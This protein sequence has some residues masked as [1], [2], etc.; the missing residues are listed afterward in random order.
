[1][2]SHNGHV[3]QA[4]VTCDLGSTSCR[5]TPDGVRWRAPWGALGGLFEVLGHRLGSAL[6]GLLKIML[7]N[8][9]G[10]LGPRCGH[11]E[12]ILGHLAAMLEH[13]KI[14]L[15]VKTYN[16]LAIFIVHSFFSSFELEILQS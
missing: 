8:I 14:V 16:S 11:F 9:L 15:F 6:V 12:F 2:S 13:L 7:E 10:L 1:M 3:S 4:Q 5:S